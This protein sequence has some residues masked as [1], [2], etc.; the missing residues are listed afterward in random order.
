MVHLLH[1][2]LLISVVFCQDPITSIIDD[3]NN[4]ISGIPPYIGDCSTTVVL[5]SNLRFTLYNQNNLQNGIVL[6]DTNLQEVNL[7]LRLIFIIHGWLQSDSQSWITEMKRVYLSNTSANII[8]VDWSLYG[9]INYGAAV[10]AVPLVGVIVGDLIYNITSGNSTWLNNTQINGHSLG[11]HIAGIAG[12]EVQ[13]KTN[14][15][16]IGRIN[17]LDA[18]GPGFINI[19]KNSRLDSQD[20]WFVQAL[21]TND[22][23]FGYGPPYGTVDFQVNRVPLLGCGAFQGGCPFNPGVAINA[24]NSILQQLLPTLFCNHGRATLYFIESI[25]SSNFISTSCSSCK[26]F[27][28]KQCESSPTIIMGEN[29]PSTVSGEYYLSTNAKAPFA[30]G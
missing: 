6:D 5:R 16:K 14:G 24:N 10:C 17:S 21:H 30:K 11:A 9:Q 19:T 15:L 28:L 29:C 4:I 22:G 26:K 27:G 2:T 23:Q 7:A 20:A 18:A 13:N 1:I 3:L 8:L 12:Q 25:S